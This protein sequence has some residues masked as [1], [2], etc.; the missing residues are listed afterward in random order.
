MKNEMMEKLG[1]DTASL[2]RKKVN[3]VWWTQ[4]F[5]RFNL[6]WIGFTSKGI[7]AYLGYCVIPSNY[8]MYFTPGYIAVENK[9][10]SDLVGMMTSP[11]QQCTM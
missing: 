11:T 10:C 3:C 9:S 2:D 1:D 8:N 5:F 6:C 7:Q 4:K